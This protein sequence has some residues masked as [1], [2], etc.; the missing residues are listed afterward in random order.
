MPYVTQAY[1]SN[2][3]SDLNISVR[4]D[5][6][7]AKQPKELFDKIPSQ[8]VIDIAADMG[9]SREYNALRWLRERL[10]EAQPQF[11]NIED[12]SMYTVGIGKAESE[13]NISVFDIVG[14]RRCFSSED[15]R[16]LYDAIRIP[17]ARGRRVYISF[18]DIT[19]ISAAF[20]DAAMGRLC[21]GEFSDEMITDKLSLIET[22]PEKIFLVRRAFLEAKEFYRDPNRFKT[23]IDSLAAEGDLD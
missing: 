5:Y 8:P 11:R 13:E 23:A 1:S 22:P 4:A 2:N 15:G 3:S 16:R 10:K 6:R 7:A 9:F 12:V 20:L 14:K 17:L 19:N 18:K 21:D